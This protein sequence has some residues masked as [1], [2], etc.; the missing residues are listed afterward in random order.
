M[1]KVAAAYIYTNVVNRP[2]GRALSKKHQIAH[3]QILF[4]HCGTALG[5][6]AGHARD[7]GAEMP[8]HVLRKT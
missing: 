2:I 3:A 5:L 4:A 1:D 7:V 8:H 6:V